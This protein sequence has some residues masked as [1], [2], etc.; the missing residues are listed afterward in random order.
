MG[1][2][3]VVFVDGDV[4]RKYIRQ[5]NDILISEGYGLTYWPYPN[6]N[7]IQFRWG[8]WE[9]CGATRYW[10]PATPGRGY[11]PV[12]RRVIDV[13]DTCTPSLVYYGLDVDDGDSAIVMTPQNM[14]DFDRDWEAYSDD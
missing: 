9:W 1:I 13:L 3:A 12:I 4:P 5:A 6:K 7:P 10:H 11:W 2:D 14:A 8:R